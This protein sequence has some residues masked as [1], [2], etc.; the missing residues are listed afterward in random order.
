MGYLQL[1]SILDATTVLAELV[2]SHLRQALGS[3]YIP[4]WRVVYFLG[5]STVEEIYQQHF[6]SVAK[7]MVYMLV[8][9]CNIITW[10]LMLI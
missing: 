5:N 4:T 1:L 9:A 2:S 6:L 8:H 7:V 10:L 3:C